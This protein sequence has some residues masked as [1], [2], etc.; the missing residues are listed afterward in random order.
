M[1]AEEIVMRIN[2][3]WKKLF[4]VVPFLLAVFLLAAAPTFDPRATGSSASFLL[5]PVLS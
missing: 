4:L 2:S 1:R 5:P 3:Q